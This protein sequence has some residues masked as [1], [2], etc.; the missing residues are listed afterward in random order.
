MA[1]RA[2]LR[3]TV[4][5][6]GRAM[7][8]GQATFEGRLVADREVELAQGARARLVPPV[9]T[10]PPSLTILAPPEPLVTV[11]PAVDLTVL[12][13]DA[14]PGVDPASFSL[15]LN[16]TLVSDRCS[17]GESVA[18]CSVELGRRADMR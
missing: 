6:R 5:V 14:D 11:E 16:G 7:L 17:V 8:G 12:Y 1:S 2:V 3:A 15:R 10:A 9:D 18:F 4:R 13:A